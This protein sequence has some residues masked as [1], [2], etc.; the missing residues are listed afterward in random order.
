MV[1]TA[2]ES[3]TNPAG[4][5]GSGGCCWCLSH[6]IPLWVLCSKDT[7]WGAADTCRARIL[8]DSTWMSQLCVSISVRGH[9]CDVRL[10]V[11]R[12][13]EWHPAGEVAI[14]LC[15]AAVPP[16]LSLCTPP[17]RLAVWPCHLIMLLYLKARD[18]VLGTKSYYSIRKSNRRKGHV[19]FELS[20][21]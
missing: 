15:S 18:P 9:L 10:S 1:A 14:G 20:V 5:P 6:T 17:V 3:L 2:R 13:T 11:A 19:I 7:A 21:K 16:L 4:G 8:C 12:R